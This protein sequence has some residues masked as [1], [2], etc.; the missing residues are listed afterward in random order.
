MGVGSS[1]TGN[2]ILVQNEQT[3]Y[4]TWEFLYD[5]RIEKLKLAAA[6]NGGTDAL[7][8][9]AFGQSPG[10]TG[11][12]ASGFG[13]SSGGFGQSPSST[14]QSPSSPNGTNQPPLP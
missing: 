10:S 11:Q 7:G 5:P 12:P 9:G 1:A 4:Q 14:G 6:L 2:S 3:T 8:G 13:Q